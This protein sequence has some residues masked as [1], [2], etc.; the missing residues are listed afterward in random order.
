ME[1]DA[2]LAAADASTAGGREVSAVAGGSLLQALSGLGM[3][4]DVREAL[5]AQLERRSDPAGTLLRGVVSSAG[6]GRPAPAARPRRAGTA[7][8]D[9]A[10][11]WGRE[12]AAAG[13]LV[14]TA[15]LTEEDLEAL[16][17]LPAEPAGRLA[18][19][20]V[21]EVAA[22]PVP[23][24]TGPVLSALALVLREVDAE[25][26]P[27]ADLLTVAASPDVD[28]A[29]RE[30]VV[31][32]LARATTERILRGVA[33]ALHDGVPP[34]A[35]AEVLDAVRRAGGA[36][37]ARPSP[38]PPT[39]GVA[40]PPVYRGGPTRAEP[41]QAGPGGDEATMGEPD[42]GPRPGP[43]AGP[44]VELDA[45]PDVGAGAGPGGGSALPPAYP[46]IDVTTKTAHPDVVVLG[47]A[48]GLEVGLGPRPLPTVV[49][50]GAVLGSG[51]VDIVVVTDPSTLAVDGPTRHTL[52]VDAEHPYPCVTLT[53]TALWTPEAAPTRRIGVHYLRGGQVV[54]VA[55][56]VLAVADDDSRVMLTAVPPVEGAGLLDLTPL[57]GPEPPDLVLTVAAG[58]HGDGSWVWSAYS[59]DASVTVPDG[60]E[61]T[62]LGD[63]I[64]GFALDGRRSIE[65]SPGRVP[66]Y[67]DLAGRA[68]L[69]GDAVPPRVAEAVR[70]LVARPGRPTAPTVLLLTEEPVVPWEMA[71]LRLRSAWGG[72]S[73]FLGAHVALGRWPLVR[74]NPRPV[75]RA[76]V[77]VRSAAV[78]RADYTGL[79]K[80]PVLTQ[81]QAEADEVSALFAGQTVATV[82]ST[83]A[84]VHDLLSGTPAVDLVHVALH[85]SFDDQGSQGG[86]VLVERDAAGARWQYLTPMQVRGCR[87]DGAPFVFL[88]ACQ[89]G[90]DRKVLGSYGGMA[91]VLLQI[92]ACGVVAPLWNVDD[93][94]AAAVAR[95]VYARSWTTQPGVSVA[96]AVRAL[97][98]TYTREAV[99]SGQ[100]LVSATL[101]AFQVF[102]H[103]R[104]MLVH[105]PATTE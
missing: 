76:S 15:G 85:G 102:G 41:P 9:A 45:G 8:L 99:T 31:G 66:D 35:L 72:T 91:T 7:Q 25:R 56:R 98:A 92:G 61:A 63:D 71:D 94:V 81:A 43:S 18:L 20:L 46:R 95:E 101:M 40:P 22:L 52:V 14:L 70:S 62:S 6:A 87:L 51:D 86:L 23:R 19:R 57:V 59:G 39:T 79:P 34:D 77:T 38:Q 26:L 33:A 16:R 30:A 82:E 53:A 29:L 73:P 42:P 69:V 3:T 21:E 105:P 60:S 27:C 83:Y 11:A 58:D 67:D 28:D 54:A 32:A 50:T 5:T 104:L 49:S 88:N 100:P 24:R 74:G 103:P 65:F 17:D 48:F 1:T 44:D 13:L 47:R 96:E 89:V 36:G 37:R 90:A 10:L 78:L 75:P 97:R 84:A 93:D 55:W 64:R 12:H 68:R 80:W 2:W 4:T